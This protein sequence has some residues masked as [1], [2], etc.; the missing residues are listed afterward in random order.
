MTDRVD[1]SAFA[2]VSS[3]DEAAEADRRYW[4][5]RTPEERLQA[6]HLLRTRAYG[7]A[8]SGRVERVLE[9]TQ[10]CPR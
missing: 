4:W 1:R 2:V 9:V 6:V 8:A 7:D 5:S 3:H 10:R